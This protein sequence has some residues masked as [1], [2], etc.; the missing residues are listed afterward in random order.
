MRHRIS[1]CG[2]V[3]MELRYGTLQIDLCLFNNLFSHAK[4]YLI[5]SRQDNDACAMEEALVGMPQRRGQ[6]C[7]G[8]QCNFGQFRAVQRHEDAG[9]LRTARQQARRYRAVLAYNEYRAWRVTCNTFSD[10]SQEQAFFTGI[11]VA[12]EH[13]KIDMSASSQRDNRRGRL[14]TILNDLGLYTHSCKLA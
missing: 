1:A 9:R 8:E 14:P 6:P 12:T 3:G 13:D 11:A 4:T 5:G 7:C 10:A 2:Q